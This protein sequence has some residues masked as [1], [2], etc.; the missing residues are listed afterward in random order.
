M[1]RRFFILS[2]GNGFGSQ[3][4]GGFRSDNFISFWRTM[5]TRGRSDLEM[6]VIDFTMA[7]R[8]YERVEAAITYIENHFNDQPALGEVASHVGLSEYHFQRLFSRWVG[9]SPKR[10]L[11]FLTK[12]YAKK[13]LKGAHSVLDTAYDAGLSGPGR[14]HDLFVAC[15]AVTPGEYKTSGLGLKMVYGFYDSP[16]GECLVATTGRGLSGLFFVQGGDRRRVL[17]E[18][19]G[20]WNRARLTEDNIGLASLTERI[21]TPSAWQ[22]EKPLP[23]MLKGTNFQIK[24]WEALLR[25]PAGTAVTYEDVATAVGS[26]G[27]VRA[28]GT[29]VG[30]NPI[31]YL[32]PCHRVIRKN[33]EFGNYGSGS[34]RKKAILGWE[35]ARVAYRT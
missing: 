25:I 16:F 7:R 12:E 19:T 29:A 4:T 20:I 8:D 28:V 18:L 30:K 14:L 24:V 31:S 27:A 26:P 17:D 15:E 1:N 13:L 3:E 32:I 34:A 2:D 21:F 11:Q 22:Q 33:A 6:T 23:I 10:F 9:I 5:L 35:A